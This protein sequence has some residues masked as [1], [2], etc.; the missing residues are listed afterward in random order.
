MFVGFITEAIS[1]I[2]FPIHWNNCLF[3]KLYYCG[4]TSVS[5]GCSGSTIFKSING[6]Y[7]IITIELADLKTTYPKGVPRNSCYHKPVLT[8]FIWIKTFWWSYF[9]QWKIILFFHKSL[10]NKLLQIYQGSFF[11]I[12]VLKNSSFSGS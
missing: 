5:S 3:L 7:M 9:L 10:T 11:S 4:K 6:F 12:D 1:I 2:I 8:F